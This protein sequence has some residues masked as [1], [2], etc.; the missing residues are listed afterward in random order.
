MFVGARLSRNSADLAVVSVAWSQLLLMK[1]PAQNRPSASLTRAPP[2]PMES[3]RYSHW[4]RDSTSDR[5]RQQA[6]ARQ[7]GGY[8]D[9]PA[10]T[11]TEGEDGAQAGQ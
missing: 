8:P 4:M 2:R 11:L 9:S 5:Y 10:E 1:Q 7:H 3:I 6:P